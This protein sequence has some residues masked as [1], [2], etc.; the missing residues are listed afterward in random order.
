VKLASIRLLAVIVML[1]SALAGLVSLQP[2]TASAASGPYRMRLPAN[3]VAVSSVSDDRCLWGVGIEFPKVP[4][5]TGYSVEYWDG[6][7]GALESGTV[8]VRWRTPPA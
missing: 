4:K 2:G 8:G 6:Y 7:W 5:A 1:T 3:F